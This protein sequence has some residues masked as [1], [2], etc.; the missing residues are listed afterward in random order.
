MFY[1]NDEFFGQE[2]LT[3][4]FELFESI[5]ALGQPEGRRYAICSEEPAVVLAL[6]L[7]LKQRGG[8]FYPLLR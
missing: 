4:Q 3:E 2:Y 7:Y 6:C 1:V 5:A 8:S